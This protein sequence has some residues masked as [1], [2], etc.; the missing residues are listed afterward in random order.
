STITPWERLI[1]VRTLAF[2]SVSYAS[3]TDMSMNSY[4]DR[5]LSDCPFRKSRCRSSSI[6]NATKTTFVSAITPPSL[7][8][9]GSR[10]WQSQQYGRGVTPLT[11]VPAGLRFGASHHQAGQARRTARRRGLVVHQATSEAARFGL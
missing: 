1:R 5:G 8:T 9:T 11:E 7:S 2:Q 6:A 10:S 4:G 3:F